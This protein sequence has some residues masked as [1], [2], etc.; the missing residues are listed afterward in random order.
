METPNLDSIQF[1]AE[2]R[3]LLNILI[4]SLYTDRD[5]FL[6]ELI[7]NASDAI[8]RMQFELLTNRDVVD[9]DAEFSIRI[10]TDQ[11]QRTLT[12]SDN[13]I[14][15]NQAE[16]I[17]NL[18]TIAHSGAKAFLEAASQGGKNAADI[19]GQFGVG[20]YSAFMVA[21]QIEVV[22]RSFRPEES[23][24]RWISSGEDTYT[25]QPDE[26]EKR[27]TDIILHLKEDA[28]DYLQE[29]K[30]RQIIKTH[31]DYVAY[32]IYLNE[33]E[34]AA[35]QQ[36][37]LWRQ[38]PSQ[39]SEEAY[40]D[41]YR[42]FTLDT[43]EPLLKL[44]LSIDAPV[45][46]YALLY[47][48]TSAERP[49]FSLRTDDG[50]KL[51]ARKVLIQEYSKDL[52][53]NY[54]RFVDGVVDSEDIPLNVSRESIQSSRIMA[55]IKKVITGK[56][57]DALKSFGKEKPEEYA[58]FWLEF[59]RAIREGLATDAENAAALKPL[60]RFHS[61]KHPADWISLDDYCLQMPAAQ[62]QIYYLLG[63]DER[64]L[65]GSPHLEMVQKGDFDV[66]FLADPLDP[67]ML[68]QVKDYDGHNLVNL[69]GKEAE[70][71]ESAAEETK[72][73]EDES[74]Q[75]ES[76]QALLERVKQVLGDQ[77]SDVRITRRL[78]ESP[79][80]LVYADDA[81]QPEM[82]KVYRLLNKT[83]EQ[84]KRVLEINPEHPLWRGLADLPAEQPLAQ[85]IIEQ[86]FENTL[87]L[88]GQQPDAAKMT[89][90]VQTLM[91]AVLKN[92]TK[93]A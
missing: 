77:I 15:M 50:I 33:S 87:I 63:D 23:A 41:F 52:L 21:D 8:T 18:G 93:E 58:K 14:G 31:S 40:K 22:S 90:R 68:M 74:E 62:T 59:G 26:K 73:D 72:P 12:I 83:S 46:L 54:L 17:E 39:V 92:S 56:V 25:I 19:I 9:P 13:G 85:M 1:K 16:M 67:F 30:L 35:N 69:A 37:S 32:P 28:A 7:S 43:N 78:V 53:P 55:Q 64:S 75:P 5:V 71:P 42:Q 2:T 76:Q 6:R 79:A 82:E 27:G 3:Q 44:H 24:S 47:I 80:R 65:S 49:F 57:I 91:E 60:L 89:R 20:F 66:L 84:P 11:D 61:R 10:K 86:I 36:T 4:H 38:T 51:F 29:Y 48:P 45:Q 88:E 81:I 70:I 34:E